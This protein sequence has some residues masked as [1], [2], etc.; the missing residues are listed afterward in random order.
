[1]S[2]MKREHLKAWAQQPIATFPFISKGKP[3][4][5]ALLFASMWKPGC[6]HPLMSRPHPF[7]RRHV[8][9]FCGINL[10]F[11]LQLITS[12]PFLPIRGKEIAWVYWLQINVL[13]VSHML[14]EAWVLQDTSLPGNANSSPAAGFN[15][16]TA[17]GIMW[18]MFWCC[19]HKAR[20][21]CSPHGPLFTL[22]L[23]SIWTGP[24]PLKRYKGFQEWRCGADHLSKS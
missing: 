14:S 9:A 2:R 16:G 20:M 7:T 19:L 8:P 5:R 17:L 10:C 12:K 15:Q 22:S 6:N 21:L 13:I 18:D 3:H 23:L 1:M 4:T 11:D 24:L